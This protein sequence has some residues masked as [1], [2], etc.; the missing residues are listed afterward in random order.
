MGPGEMVGQ[1]LGHYQITRLIGLGGMA[2]VFLA[3][4]TYLNREVALKVFKPREDGQ[5]SFLH[6]FEREAQIV[7][8]LEHPNILTVYEYGRYNGMAYFVMPYL[9]SGSL[10]NYLQRQQRLSPRVALDLLT[11]ILRALQYAHDRG[12]I[13]RDIKPDNML[14]KADHSLVLSDFGLVKVLADEA[15]EGTLANFATHTNS[16]MGTPQYM[17]PEQIQGKAVPASDIYSL[18]VVLYELLTGR[19]PFIA[20]TAIRVL[21]MHLYEPPPSLCGFNPQLSEALEAVV[22]RAL[23]KEA[24]QRYQRPIDFLYALMRVVVSE[25]ASYA[26][27]LSTNQKIALPSSNLEG[28]WFSD[29]A[30]VPDP[31]VVGEYRSPAHEALPPVPAPSPR[32]KHSQLSTAVLPATIARYAASQQRTTQA[33]TRI[34]SV[35][36]FLILLALIPLG[37]LWIWPALMAGHSGSHVEQG[38]IS[39]ATASADAMLTTSCPAA[40]RARP[41]VLTPL[42]TSSP[43]HQ[44]MIYMQQP[45][46]PV[47]KDAASALMRYDSETARNIV[48]SQ[49]PGERLGRAQISPDGQWILFVAIAAQKSQLQLIRIDGKFLQTLYCAPLSNATEPSIED[50]Y[51][52]PYTYADG[53]HVLFSIENGSQFYQLWLAN[54][55]I[56]LKIVAPKR[57]QLVG[58][59]DALHLY[60]RDPGSN[61]YQATIASGQAAPEHNLRQIALAAGTDCDDYTI[62]TDASI[63]VSHCAGKPTDCVQCGPLLSGASSIGRLGDENPFFVDQ[64]LAVSQ[65][66]SVQQHILAISLA[67]HPAPSKPN[68]LWLIDVSGVQTPKLLCTVDSSMKSIT[69]NESF[70]DSWSN[71]SRDGLMYALKT[72]TLRGPLV[73]TL[74]IGSL[75]SAHLKT[76]AISP[77]NA[78]LTVIGWTDR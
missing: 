34:L 9:S 18:G 16:I 77:H 57:Y 70:Q 45:G 3:R 19:V 71:V 67:E 69:L 58:W 29:A 27:P 64:F 47:S 53:A 44:S 65:I 50:I 4:D 25:N 60:L 30:M 15:D 46:L 26:F 14:F 49:F 35:I 68:G 24:E 6:R 23:A 62:G 8:Q 63:Y 74:S 54:G 12:L 36:I 38:I 76:V 17:S 56:A 20:D 55:D 61:L 32:L 21:T 28:V 37:V 75:S 48:I 78:T 66:R 52:S 5:D 2:T 72:S 7:A 1:R 31:E 10:R 51:W 42:G 13:H 40:G 39:T 22:L 59:P 41:A 43:A 73:D 33:S 11:P